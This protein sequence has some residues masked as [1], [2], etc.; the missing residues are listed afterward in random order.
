MLRHVR[1]GAVGLAVCDALRRLAFSLADSVGRRGVGGCGVAGGRGVKG[2]AVCNA[3]RRFVAQG[4]E[5]GMT[6]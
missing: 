2:D 5:G 4:R 3:L 6:W 1:G